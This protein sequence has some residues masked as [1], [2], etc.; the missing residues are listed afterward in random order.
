[1]AVI[2][3]PRGVRPDPLPILSRQKKLFMQMRGKIL[4]YYT[5]PYTG[6]FRTTGAWPRPKTCGLSTPR[7]TRTA[8]YGR[9][10]RRESGGALGG[11]ECR[12]R[13][14]DTGHK[15]S[16]V[17]AVKSVARLWQ[18]QVSLFFSAW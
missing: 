17:A 7:L 12:R 1:M 16:C 10:A 3:D 9:Y 14:A 5:Y 13:W 2:A 8:L 15:A 6:I 11:K 18:N 4:Q